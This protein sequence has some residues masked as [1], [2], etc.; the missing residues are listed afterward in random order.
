MGAACNPVC[1]LNLYI[2]GTNLYLVD[3]RDVVMKE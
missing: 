2:D 3:T 1:L